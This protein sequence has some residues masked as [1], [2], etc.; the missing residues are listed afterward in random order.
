MS[1]S[2]KLNTILLLL[3]FNV[4]DDLFIYMN[5]IFDQINLIILIHT[6]YVGFFIIIIIF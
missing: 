2:Q 1:L 5:T 6:N 4:E 3:F